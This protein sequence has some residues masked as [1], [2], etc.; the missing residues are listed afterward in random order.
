MKL[1]SCYR[2]S[3]P[4]FACSTLIKKRTETFRVAG[5]AKVQ[6]NFKYSPPKI[7][8]FFFKAALPL[9]MPYNSNAC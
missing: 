6:I 9:I 4:S 3:V 8:Y 5:K 2:E 7:N 1:M